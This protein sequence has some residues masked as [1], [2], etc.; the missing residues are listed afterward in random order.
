M[1]VKDHSLD[2]KIVKAA[3]EEFLQHG[4]QKASLHKITERAGITTGALYTRY[5]NKDALFCNLLEDAMKAMQVNAKPLREMYYAVE[6]SEN[7]EE[8]LKVMERERSL[9]LDILFQYYEEC[10]LFFCCSAGSSIEVSLE[11]MMEM[12]ATE[13]VAFFKKLSKKPVDLAGIEFVITEQ[14]QFY[15]LILQKGYS[16]EEAISCMETVEIFFEAGWK[17]LFEKIMQ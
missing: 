1:A 14:F 15:R 4:F 7:V 3:R 13:T 11:K 8:F 2:E 6:E 10:K 16:K 12:K 9:Y 17:K 5:K